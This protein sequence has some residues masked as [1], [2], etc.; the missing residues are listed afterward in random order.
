MADTTLLIT[1]AIGLRPL[2]VRGEPLHATQAQIRSAI[3]RRL[4]EGHANLLAVPQQHD[5]GT[6]IDWYAE[7]SGEPRRIAEL[8][9]S[10]RSAVLADVERL[11]SDILSLGE[12]L[13]ESG[14]S[15]ASLLGRSL[16]MA[17][18]SIPDEFVFVVGDQPVIAAWGYERDGLPPTF[19]PPT[20]SSASM[21]AVLSS[22]AAVGV[23]APGWRQWLTAL[24][25]GLLLL[26]LLFG[27]AWLLRS[28]APIDPQVAIERLP[29]PPAPPAPP[30]PPDPTPE[31]QAT[32]ASLKEAERTLNADLALLEKTLVERRAQCPPPKPPEPKVAVAPPAPKPPPP[33][34]PEPA[35]KPDLP[36]EKWKQGDVSILEGCW[37]L[38]RDSTTT[39]TTSRGTLRGINRAGRL[40]FDRGGTGTRQA[41]AEF[42]GHPTVACEAPIRVRFAGDGT[43]RTTQPQVTCNPRSVTWHSE[44]N[45]MTCRRVSDSVAV[46]RDAQGFEHEFRREA[47]R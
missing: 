18:R 12:Q 36:E 44:P 14:T 25:L 40:C 1:T 20:I 33:K 21:P 7:L 29:P 46:C 15:E 43:M 34:P 41:R 27:S 39:M 45:Y 31:K 10:E 16:Q 9:A 23:P 38:G 30:P 11:L 4:S 26:L 28:C 32:L 8:S 47:G 13:A 3:R 19:L 35:K 17:G 37:T 42:Q 22:V 5:H 24:L 6:A 2:G